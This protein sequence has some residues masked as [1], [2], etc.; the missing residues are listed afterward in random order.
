MISRYQRWLYEKDKKESVEALNEWVLKESE[1]HNIAM[2]TKCGLDGSYQKSKEQ[3][4][5]FVNSKQRDCKLCFKPHGTWE[6]SI[7]NR[8]PVTERWQ[9]AKELRLC[10]RCLG[11][12]H[13][14]SNCRRMKKCGIN[15][16]Q[17]THHRLL[18]QSELNPQASLFSPAEIQE[19]TE[20]N[21]NVTQSQTFTSTQNG[22][23][24][25]RTVPVI[26]KANGREIVINAL[27]D[28]GSTKTYLNEDVAAELGLKSVYETVVVNTLNEKSVNFETMCV[29]YKLCSIDRQTE[30]EMEAYTTQNVAGN[31][32]PTNWFNYAKRWEHLKGIQ[33]PS[34]ERKPKVDLL[35][36]L[37]Y[38]ALHTCLREVNGP[39]GS[40]SARLTPLGWTC[41]GPILEKEN[42]VSMFTFHINSEPF[43]CE[44]NETLRK[45]WELEN[46]E[47]E[48]VMYISRENEKVMNLM[49]SEL[50]YD[51]KLHRYEVPVPWK[52]N[53][54]ELSNNYNMAYDRLK[55]NERKLNSNM[56][57][58]DCYR[59]TIEKYEEKGYIS[60]LTNCEAEKTKWY[61]P[62]F[63]VVRPD[64]DTTKVRIF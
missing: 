23:I 42:E 11:N 4:S 15:G 36:G 2:E 26:L 61:L 52:E 51:Q 59:N 39:V 6:C 32:K 54:S 46:V 47:T 14:G 64:K 60:K 1:F 24:A 8:L 30:I 3:R 58:K 33:F 19:N 63:P 40:P 41:V 18:Y 56:E 45:C 21:Q 10:F 38:L 49:K 16:C 37:D 7:M 55:S 44:I 9:K 17:K 12:N 34:I 5:F 20:Q 57:L 62:H 25:L 43:D 53:K 13:T 50:Q 28:D 31:L 48:Q 27:L 29:K 22:Y 35:I